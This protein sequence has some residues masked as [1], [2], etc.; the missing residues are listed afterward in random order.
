MWYEISRKT[1]TLDNHLR[2]YRSR[3]IGGRW[4]RPCVSVGWPA[5]ALSLD[6]TPRQNTALTLWT[7]LPPTATLSSIITIGTYIH[8]LKYIITRQCSFS[9]LRPAKKQTSRLAFRIRIRRE[10]PLMCP[11]D[12]G[13]PKQLADFFPAKSR[14]CL[15]NCFAKAKIRTKFGSRSALRLYLRWLD[16]YLEPQKTNADPKQGSCRCSLTPSTGKENQSN[17][18]HIY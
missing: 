11:L 15:S 4:H 14:I 6:P 18:W 2:R 12:P 10:P 16:S 3:W 7:L 5:A 13:I 1:S 17:F 9:S 8:Q